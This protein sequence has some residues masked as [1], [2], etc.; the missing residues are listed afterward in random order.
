MMI[1]PPFSEGLEQALD[2]LRDSHSR[3]RV[4]KDNRDRGSRD[5]RASSLDIGIN[6]N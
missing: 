3:G 2:S 6:D 1:S 5:S 4:S